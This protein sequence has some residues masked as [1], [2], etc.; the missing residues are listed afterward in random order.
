MD[1][2]PEW[3]IAGCAGLGLLIT[4][5]STVIG[6]AIWLMRRLDK[7][8]EEILADFQT[9]HDANAQTVE[10][11]KVLVIRHDVQLNPEFNGTGS[12]IARNHK[13]SPS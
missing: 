5:T 7:L 8:K 3:I 4:W 12:R 9:K 2:K 6:A 11:L 10:A 1:V 13:H